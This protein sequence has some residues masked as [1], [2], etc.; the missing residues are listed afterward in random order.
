[1]LRDGTGY[2]HL[3]DLAAFGPAISHLTLA[4]TVLRAGQ[5]INVLPSHAWLDMDIRTLPGHADDYVD[6]LLTQVL[7]DLATNVTFLSVFYTHL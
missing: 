6:D 1:A 5:A 3:G 4:Q 2:E 7:G